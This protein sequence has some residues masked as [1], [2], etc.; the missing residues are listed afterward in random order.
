VFLRSTPPSSGES[1]LPSQP[2]LNG[3][4]AVIAGEALNATFGP[5][6]CP[7][8]KSAASRDAASKLPP[9]IAKK[10]MLDLWRAISRSCM[11]TRDVW[12]GSCVTSHRAEEHIGVTRDLKSRGDVALSVGAIR[13]ASFSHEHNSS[14]FKDASSSDG[15]LVSFSRLRQTFQRMPERK[16]CHQR[17]AARGKDQKKPRQG[18]AMTKT[19]GEVERFKPMTKRCAMRTRHFTKLTSKRR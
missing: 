11:T 6:T 12:S 14:T 10:P 1:K 8:T 16:P 18:E 4:R 19:P 17:V 2:L 15:L 13:N 5:P 7:P 3:Q 9:I